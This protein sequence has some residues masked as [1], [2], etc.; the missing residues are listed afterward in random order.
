MGPTRVRRRPSQAATL[1]AMNPL[2]SSCLLY[3][4]HKLRGSLCEYQR[5]FR[6]PHLPVYIAKGRGI[7]TYHNIS[8]FDGFRAG[9]Q[10]QN[11]RCLVDEEIKSSDPRTWLPGAWWPMGESTCD[12]R[13]RGLPQGKGGPRGLFPVDPPLT[14]RSENISNNTFRLAPLI[15]TKDG[16]QR[17]SN[18]T[19]LRSIIFDLSYSPGGDRHH[20]FTAPDPS[21]RSEFLSSSYPAD[22]STP[23]SHPP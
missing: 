1:S 23:S 11:S 15:V 9:S 19:S 10:E 12:T 17:L 16:S 22:Q 2:F 5:P 13:V 14:S 8:H 21:A 4:V 20:R 18:A 3:S 6:R 7:G